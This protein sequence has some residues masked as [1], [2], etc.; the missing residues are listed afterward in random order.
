MIPLITLYNKTVIAVAIAVP[1][2]SNSSFIK[3]R[4]N[5]TVVNNSTTNKTILYGT[6]IDIVR[7]AYCRKSLQ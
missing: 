6:D 1:V 7:W 4:F 3:I 5:P 2:M